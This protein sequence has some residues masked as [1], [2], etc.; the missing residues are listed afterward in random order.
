MDITQRIFQDSWSSAT[1]TLTDRVKEVY[2]NFQTFNIA[3]VK[4]LLPETAVNV[5]PNPAIDQIQIQITENKGAFTATVADVTGKTWLTKTFQSGQ[6]NAVN[7]EALPKGVYLLQLQT[8]NG[9]VV[10]RIVKQ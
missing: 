5:Y 2:S 1:G 7:I 8:E 9:T 10:K 4:D 3:G 6:E